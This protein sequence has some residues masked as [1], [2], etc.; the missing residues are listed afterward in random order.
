MR[1][2][3]FLRSIGGAIKHRLMVDWSAMAITH[4]LDQIPQLDIDP[5]LASRSVINQHGIAVL[6]LLPV[7]LANGRLV[8]SEVGQ[9]DFN[10]LLIKEIFQCLDGGFIALIA[11]QIDA[12]DMCPGF[13]AGRGV[14][15]RL[16]PPCTCL[17]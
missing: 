16:L 4:C 9:T 5:G 6:E 1:K 13:T 7:D 10:S 12:G 11:N 8:F 2:R 17:R 3:S 15:V 14:A